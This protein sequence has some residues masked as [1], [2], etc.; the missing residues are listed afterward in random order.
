ML[1][2]KFTCHHCGAPKVNS[3]K[4]PYI[5]C[6]YCGFMIDVDYTAGLQV[7]NHSEEHTAKYVQMKQKFEANSA[8]FLQQKNKEA[9]W[10]EHYQYWDFYYTHFPEYLPPTIPAGEKYTLF[11]KAAA[12]MA[13]DAMHQTSSVKSEIYTRAY[14]SLVYY[15]KDNKNFVNY[16]S[17]LKMIE[18]YLDFQQEGFRTMY[19]NPEY[20]IMN[21]LLPEKFQLKM[22]LSQIAQVWIPYLEEENTADFL[23]RYQL[24]HEYVEAKEPQRIQHKCD[25]CGKEIHAPSGALVSICEHCRYRNTL[26]KTVKCHNCGFENELPKDWNQMITCSAC[27]TQLRVVQPLF[28]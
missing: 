19:D 18:A 21:E 7:W 24:K 14:Q 9:Y 22:K 6:D 28:G 8:K 12:D 13:V 15:Q 5:V 4:N 20:H 10:K 23:D 17:F 27:S 26:K 3:Y 2:K 11:I 25:G 16:A 1:V